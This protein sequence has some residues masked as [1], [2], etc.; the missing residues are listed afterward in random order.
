MVTEVVATPETSDFTGVKERSEDLKTTIDAALPALRVPSSD[1]DGHFLPER[2]ERVCGG[3]C[4]QVTEAGWACG[5]CCHDDHPDGDTV[6]GDGSE[7]DR[8]SITQ[9]SV[10]FPCHQSTYN[11]RASVL[12]F[13]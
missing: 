6:G 8:R 10:R 13:A 3:V 11:A 2:R 5:W 1:L 9:W 12:C 4:G 7:M